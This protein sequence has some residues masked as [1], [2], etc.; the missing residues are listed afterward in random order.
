VH[1][2]ATEIIDDHTD[3]LISLDQVVLFG[4]AYIRMK[5][6]KVMNLLFENHE[7]DKSKIKRVMDLYS[8]DSENKKIH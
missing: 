8:H 2:T 1:K 5:P 7:V 6:D 4:I 3:N